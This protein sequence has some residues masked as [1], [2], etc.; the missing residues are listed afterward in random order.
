MLT[1]R[2][3]DTLV[4]IEN[5]IR[6]HHEAPTIEEIA[7]GIGISSLG[8]TYT[9]ISQL[10]E[11]G[12]LKRFNNKS[13]GLELMSFT[14]EQDFA[15]PM[16]GKIAA[17]RLIEAVPDETEI[18]VGQMFAGKGRYVLKISGMSMM[19]EGIRSGDYVVI[20]STRA[21]KHKDIVVAL[22][23][24]TDATLKTLLI[25]DDD[26]VTLMPANPDFEAI[27][28]G[29]RRVRIQGVVVGQMRTYP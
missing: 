13:R 9:Y 20:D 2:A 15:L 7:S 25:N 24:N 17:G 23:D 10:V 6:E 19:N 12:K 3:K 26:T 21:A 18:N 28:L 8:S 27:T 16:M 5:Y 29:A 22:V 4:F 14:T 1:K 11:A